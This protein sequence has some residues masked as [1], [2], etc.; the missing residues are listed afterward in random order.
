MMRRE[1]DSIVAFARCVEMQKAEGAPRRLPSSA[2][3]SSDEPAKKANDG[4]DELSCIMLEFVEVEVF[5]HG[6]STA[7]SLPAR[8]SAHWSRIARGHRGSDAA[9]TMVV[10][11]ELSLAVHV[12]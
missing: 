6:K 2:S 9:V 7:R 5:V 3:P 10:T 4:D 8:K 12:H 1:A 11:D